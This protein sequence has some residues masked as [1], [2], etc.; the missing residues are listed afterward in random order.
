MK[1][2]SAVAASLAMV[3]LSMFNFPKANAQDSDTASANNQFGFKLLAKLSAQEKNKNIFISPLS[4]GQVMKMAASGA[5]GETREEICKTLSLPANLSTSEMNK[6]DERMID[7]I[8]KKT[9]HPMIGLRNQKADNEFKLSIANSLWANE[10]FSLNRNFVST[11]GKSYKAMVQN[12]NFSDPSSVNKINSW[13]SEQTNGKIPS[14]LQKLSASQLMVLVNATYFKAAWMDQFTKQA[15][16]DADFHTEKGEVKKVP[17]MVQGG[18][19]IY[20]EHD[21][22]Q[23]ISLPYADQKTNMFIILPKKNSSTDQLIGT[24]ANDWKNVSAS[25]SSKRGTLFLPRFKFEYS[26]QLADTLS[27]MGMKL[28]FTDKADFL[29]M[30]NKPPSPFVSQVIHKTYVDVNEEGTEAAA[31]TA[32]TFETAALRREEV[33]KPFEMRVDR[34]FL[35]AITN[36]STGAIIFLGSVKDII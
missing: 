24:F 11:C 22:F 13:A 18:K 15:T 9:D 25:L 35:F 2:R 14:I 23:I 7:G 36:Q 5:Q 10:Q 20:A 16:Q 26:T 3:T 30:V 6:N 21:K 27:E 34:P 12:L 33:E 32:M 8:L 1:K 31:V 19:M 17:T 28:A 4:I 29:P